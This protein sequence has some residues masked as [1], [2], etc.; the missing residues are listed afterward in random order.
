MADLIDRDALSMECLSLTICPG[1]ERQYIDAM[2]DRI[3]NAPTIDAIPVVRCKECKHYS[4]EQDPCH[5]RTARFC[6]L[7]KG[8][9]VITKDSFCSYAERRK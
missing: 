7:H 2:Y 6:R 1:F 4:W 9:T 5:G 3:K 8:L